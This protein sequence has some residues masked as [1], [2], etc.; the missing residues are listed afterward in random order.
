MSIVLNTGGQNQ[1]GRERRNGANNLAAEVLGDFEAGFDMV[2]EYDAL[3]YGKWAGIAAQPKHDQWVVPQSIGDEWWEPT[4]DAVSGL[5][6]AQ[7]RQNATSTFGNLGVYVD[8]SNSAQMQGRSLLSAVRGAP[9]GGREST[10]LPVLS[11]YSPRNATIDILGRGDYR[12]P[13][14]WFIEPPED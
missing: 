14:E 10:V 6:Y 1:W 5:W 7:P 9:T 4:T 12:V 3:Q 2:L 13:I 8:G 11:P